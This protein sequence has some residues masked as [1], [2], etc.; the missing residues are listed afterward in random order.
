MI[1]YLSIYILS[2]LSV[3]IHTKVSVYILGY[4]STYT[5]TQITFLCYQGNA[6]LAEL[7]VS[8]EISTNFMIENDEVK[9]AMSDVGL[10]NLIHR[11]WFYCE[12]DTQLMITSISTLITYTENS[13]AG[14]YG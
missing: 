7:V 3:Y 8:L 10:A 11:L 6:Y 12:S 4:L 13:P 5:L 2:Y 9:E 1:G 14:L